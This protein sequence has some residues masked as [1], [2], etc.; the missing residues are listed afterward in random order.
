[1]R[2]EITLPEK[3]I[4]R[5]AEILPKEELDSFLDSYKEERQYGLRFNPIK[6]DEETFLQACSDLE[7]E[8]IPW[9]KEGY[10]YQPSTQPGKKVLHEAGAYYIQEPSAMAVVEMLDPKPGECIL[11]LCAAPGGKS[12]QI[13]GRMMGQGLLVSNEIIS[14]R[15]KILSQNIERMGI[16]N[17]IVTNES[18]DKLA[19]I[20]PAFFD[21]IVV[22][23]PCSGEGMFRKEPEALA[24]W[25]E[26]NI[27]LCAKRQEEILE[28]AAGMLKPGGILVYSTCTFAREEDEECI[29]KFLAEHEAFTL[30]EMRRFWPH[31]HRGE[32][33]FMAKLQKRGDCQPF[34]NAEKGMLGDKRL[35]KEVQ[36]FLEKELAIP[37][38]K[39]QGR[40]ITFGEQVYLLP[41]GFDRMK[42]LKIERPG[43]H[44]ASMKKNR[45]EPA[46]ALAMASSL[47]SCE[48]KIEVS[49]KLAGAF[50]RGESLQID[51]QEIKGW[52]VLT[53]NGCSIG[54][55]KVSNG[56]LKNHYP[57]G[58]R[59]DVIF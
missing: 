49:S 57:K 4:E 25:S 7:L 12:T 26:E 38:A 46:H 34:Q 15:C 52:N 13:G 51:N 2:Y 19:V 22:D 36:E 48:K 21:R 40:L 28:N 53:T 31:R 35:M 9:A 8:K 42:G 20:F 32:G 23:A 17:C 29:E 24:Q 41:H 45:L 37:A 5:I 1:M 27:A 33:H 18:S 30:L 14:S 10:F 3:F 44:L 59:K 56:T 47:F 11:D 43:L 39:L 6:M 54:F 50:I 55:T 58:L 16:S